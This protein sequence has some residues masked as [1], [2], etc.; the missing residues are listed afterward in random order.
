M[1]GCILS[2]TALNGHGIFDNGPEGNF[3]AITSSI[4]GDGEL[5]DA[6]QGGSA[7]FFNGTVVVSNPAT[8]LTLRCKKIANI[9]GAFCANIRVYSGFLNFDVD[10]LDCDKGGPCLFWE[11][12]TVY[13]R[14]KIMRGLSDSPIW[15]EGNEP[16]EWHLSGDYIESA[17][18]NGAAGAIYFL[19]NNPRN[20]LWITVHE[21]FGGSVA[22]GYGG[23]VTVGGGRLYLDYQKMSA[24]PGADPFPLI[25]I[26]AGEAWL[27]GHKM[28][29]TNNQ[30]FAKI[31]GGRS[32]ILN[33]HW[34]D[35]GSGANVRP[36]NYLISGG[37]NSI[38][39]GRWQTTW[40]PGIKVT[41]GQLHL[42]GLTLDTSPTIQ[43]TNHAI[44][45]AGGATSFKNLTLIPG[46]TNS[47][48]SASAQNVRWYGTSNVKSNV[49][50]A[51][52]TA[53]VGTN[54][55]AD[56]DVDR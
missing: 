48:Y 16:A 51:N 45:L 42:D 4:T 28:T 38:Q 56:A 8:R 55:T 24:L 49:H 27:R 54:P 39:G 9:S 33:Q 15:V 17:E 31:S 43:H 34:E 12:G 19:P 35:A 29:V 18:T 46:G 41:G 6:G 2:N 20:K 30:A 25:E 5:K 14:F 47:V 21:I 37:T 26:T 52:I 36:Y 23:C 53:I 1:N 11:G 22:A 40:G 44:W 13:G 32:W 50:P 7:S 10:D 3:G